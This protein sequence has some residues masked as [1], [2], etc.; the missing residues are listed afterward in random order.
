MFIRHLLTFFSLSFLFFGCQ[1]TCENTVTYTRYEPVYMSFE[2]LRKSVSF[3]GAQPFEETGKIYLYGQYL[4][5]NEVNKGIHIIDNS[6]PRNPVNKSFIS[7]PGNVDMAVRNDVLYADSYVDLLA[8]DISN[9][10][11]PREAKRLENVFPAYQ[12]WPIVQAANTR[13]FPA[14]YDAD[15]GVITDF[16]ETTVTE[17][18]ECTQGGVGTAPVLWGRPAVMM[19]FASSRADASSGGGGQT[20]TGGSMARFTIVKDVLYTVDQNSM[21]VFD[22]RNAQNPYRDTSFYAGFGIETIFPYENNL[23]IGARTGMYIYNIDNP[24]A[25]TYVSTYSHANACDPVV[26]QGN[27]AYVT[28]RDGNECETFTNQLDVV[29]I[30]N[31]QQPKLTATFQMKNPHGLGIDGNQLFICEGEHGLKYFDASDPLKIGERLKQW[32]KSF[33]AFDAIPYNQVLMVIGR[34]GLYQFDY[35]DTKELKL[36]SKLSLPVDES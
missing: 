30:S 4:L 36:L 10:Q 9:I 18:N 2:N 33:H 6:D 21:R 19:E 3:E 31:L 13:F 24:K 32:D 22:I 35:S 7:I 8:I 11:Q 34:D 12:V 5:I 1:D 28:L 26:V 27:Y 23:F 17:T 29:D 20:G 14:G 15:K 25:P 16:V